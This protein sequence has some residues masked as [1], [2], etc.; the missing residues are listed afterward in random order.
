[1][2]GQRPQW[3]TIEQVRMPGVE[4]EGSREATREKSRWEP[5]SGG[6]ASSF[7]FQAGKLV[8]RWEQC[9]IGFRADA[10]WIRRDSHTGRK[11]PIN[12]PSGHRKWDWR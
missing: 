11:T 7:I 8:L 5:Q 2:K 1:M 3:R 12:A 4:R 9:L 6:H 10:G